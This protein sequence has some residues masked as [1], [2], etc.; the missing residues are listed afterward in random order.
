MSDAQRIATIAATLAV[1]GM[2]ELGRQFQYEAGRRP[3]IVNE[4]TVHIAKA[5]GAKAAKQF[6]RLAAEAIGMEE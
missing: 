3:E 1:A 4:A 6:R 5:Y 2:P